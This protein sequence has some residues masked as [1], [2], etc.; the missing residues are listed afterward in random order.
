VRVPKG[1]SLFVMASA[2]SDMFL[3]MGSRTPGG[4]VID[5]TVVHLPVVGN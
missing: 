5:G 1:K 4:I 3:G 2:F